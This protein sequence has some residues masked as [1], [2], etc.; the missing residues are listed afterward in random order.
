MKG[1]CC[2]MSVYANLRGIV[3]YMSDTFTREALG[4]EFILYDYH[5]GLILLLLNTF[6]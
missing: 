6:N 2:K 3:L 5:W 1:F 4:A